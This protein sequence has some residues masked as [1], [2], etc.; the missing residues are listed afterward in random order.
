M[1]SVHITVHLYRRRFRLQ[2]KGV[3]I[4][5]DNWSEWQ[6][7]NLRP[8]RPE[9]GARAERSFSPRPLG[10]RLANDCRESNANIR[11]R[12]ATNVRAKS[13]KSGGPGRTRTSNQTVM[14]GRL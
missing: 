7:L 11:S 3:D 10:Q 2:Q 4:S 6:D 8:P 9:R 5:K 1:Q 12:T 13:L 14:S